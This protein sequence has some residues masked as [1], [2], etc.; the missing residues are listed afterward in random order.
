LIYSQA[1]D[2]ACL[3]SHFLI[4][5]Q[6]LLSSATNLKKMI[7]L[8]YATVFFTDW[9]CQTSFDDG[10][11]ADAIPHDTHHYHVIANRL[12]YGDD[13]LAYCQEH[14]LA[15]SFVEQHLYDRP[16]RVLWGVA[17]NRL[18]SGSAATYEELAAQHFQRFVR[19]HERPI[20]SGVDWDGLR[21]AWEGLLRPKEE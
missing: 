7:R 21:K 11:S 18:L 3:R 1:L 16:S 14:E 8:K 4:G 17:H 12:G 15:H 19:A 2:P 5:S 9:G 20:S 10:T 13:V 6:A